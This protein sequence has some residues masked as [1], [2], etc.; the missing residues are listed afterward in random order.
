MK[1]SSGNALEDISALQTKLRQELVERHAG[2]YL[3]IASIENHRLPYEVKLAQQDKSWFEARANIDFL[4][5]APEQSKTIALTHKTFKQACEQLYSN[6]ETGNDY[7]AN[8]KKTL[9]KH[10]KTLTG[11]NFAQWTRGPHAQDA[12]KTGYLLYYLHICSKSGLEMLTKPGEPRFAEVEL[13]SCHHQARHKN[14]RA[15]EQQVIVL[16]AWLKELF[17]KA[18]FHRSEVERAMLKNLDIIFSGY[19]RLLNF[20]NQQASQ[21]QRDTMFTQLFKTSTHKHRQ[22]PNQPLSIQLMRSWQ[23][24]V[25]AHNISS[26]L[27]QPL[28][29][30]FL[31]ANQSSTA[32][33][34]NK[35]Y[36]RQDQQLLQQAAKLFSWLL[37]QAEYKA[38]FK[39]LSEAETLAMMKKTKEWQAQIYKCFQHDF[40]HG[41]QL[42]AKGIANDGHKTSLFNSLKTLVNNNQQVLKRPLSSHLILNL[43]NNCE[44]HYNYFMLRAQHCCLH[45]ALSASAF[46]SAYKT[47]HLQH[48][49]R[50]KWLARYLNAMSL[51]ELHLDILRINKLMSELTGGD[52]RL[53]PPASELDS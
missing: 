20:V 5:R 1:T 52:F 8:V 47:Q 14:H 2:S 18:L 26:Q 42:V 35:P 36:K 15:D 49:N 16:S 48:N 30:A 24:K 38:V 7:F 34:K 23:M 41:I 28:I 46:I 9:S 37:F 45:S 4:Y 17:S 53:L 29:D 25:Q 13:F 6:T 11:Q 43:N 21:E 44:T 12:F 39:T 40:L 32:A 31:A 50:L 10:I 33:L 27:D 22:L 3:P 51:P 19:S